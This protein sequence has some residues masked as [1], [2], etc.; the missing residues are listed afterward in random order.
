MFVEKER[1]ARI[2][3]SI[4]KIRDF[5]GQY[6]HKSAFERRVND[7]YV[8]SVDPQDKFV[9]KVGFYPCAVVP[10]YLKGKTLTVVYEKPIVFLNP[11]PDEELFKESFRGFDQ[12][13]AER[14]IAPNKSKIYYSES[15]WASDTSPE[16]LYPTLIFPRELI[17]KV[18]TLIS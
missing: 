13:V 1:H 16:G 17:G 6:I 5:E 15:E 2:D 12:T 14:R 7:E 10:E 11:R 18:V 4:R 3:I 8:V 9:T